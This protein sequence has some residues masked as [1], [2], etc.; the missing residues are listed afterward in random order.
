MG[1]WASRVLADQRILAPELEAVAMD[2][3]KL[4]AS[5]RQQSS[6]S[7]LL[8][9]M[10]QRLGVVLAQTAISAGE[11]EITCSERVIEQI[12]LKDLV[13]T[14]DALHTQTS[15]ATSVIE[16][17]G[18]YLL[19]VKGNQPK[20]FED[21]RYCFE[22]DRFVQDTI[23]EVTECEQHCSR[24]EERCLRSTSILK[25]YV[26]FPFVEQVLEIT[27]FVKDKK[28]GLERIETGYAVTSLSEEK[29]TPQQLLKIWREHWHIENKLYYVR[30][31]TF[32]EDLSPVRTGNIPP[33][34]ASLRNTAIGAL[35]AIG[36]ENIASALR[37][38]SAKPKI[39]FQAMGLI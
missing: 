6:G 20:L 17:D 3:K 28:T 15:L 23:T 12:C 27:R 16:K 21:I 13:V 24:I 26:E 4:R 5:G 29:A 37:K 39:A 2:G 35:R 9:V 22:Q 31:V 8:S 33:A 25:D 34:M 36:F 18:D 10:S 1:N 14:V 11:N 38:Y 7:Y 19:V 30:D 32:G